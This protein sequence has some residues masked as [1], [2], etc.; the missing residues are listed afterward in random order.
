MPRLSFHAW[1][2][3]YI[4]NCSFSGILNAERL[5]TIYIDCVES[6]DAPIF[7]LNTVNPASSATL[8]FFPGWIFLLKLCTKSYKPLGVLHVVDTASFVSGRLTESTSLNRPVSKTWMSSSEI[9]FNW[10]PR[11]CLEQKF[12]VIIFLLLFEFFNFFVWCAIYRHRNV[13]ADLKVTNF[14]SIFWSYDP[15]KSRNILQF[16]S[17]RST[18]VLFSGPLSLIE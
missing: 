7:E 18:F 8:G 13:N 16:D 15:R 9:I 1:K 10:R 11:R 14:L 5:S 17:A 3:M 2:C 6:G 4:L 12:S